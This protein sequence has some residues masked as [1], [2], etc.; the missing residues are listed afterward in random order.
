MVCNTEICLGI[1]FINFITFR[2]VTVIQFSANTYSVQA[3]ISKYL[4]NRSVQEITVKPDYIM[5]YKNKAL[6]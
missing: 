4:F 5:W 3:N 2:I 6:F 1:S